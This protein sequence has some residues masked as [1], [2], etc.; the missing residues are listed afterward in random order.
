MCTL[1]TIDKS[2]YTKKVIK[3]IEKDMEWNPHGYSLLTITDKGVA[4]IVRTMDPNLI[5]AVLDRGDWQRMFLHCRMA[6]QG[7]KELENT[8]GWEN[9]GV[10][11]MHNGCLRDPMSR[12]FPVDSQ[13]IGYKL[14][15]ENMPAI[16][17]WLNT[18]SFANV[19][20]IN[21]T[22]A[23]YQVYR[24]ETGSLHTDGNGN[25][26][27]N[28]VSV[29]RSR[30][31]PKT[32]KSFDLPKK[33]YRAPWWDRPT[34]IGNASSYLR[35]EK[36]R[37]APIDDTPPG[38]DDLEHDDFDNDGLITEADWRRLTASDI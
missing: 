37:F 3:R 22:H 12:A 2:L 1:M 21:V 18:E 23:W 9:A 20:F 5:F 14:E 6:T 36:G 24:S 35:T 33:P 31:I 8:H 19:F 29:M 34:A 26:S 7:A 27:S 32:V 38:F 30:V 11:Y 4:S 25:Y 13:L 15:T 10:F 17:K 28:Q 16:L